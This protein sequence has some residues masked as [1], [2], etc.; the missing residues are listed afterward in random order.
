[1]TTG[2]AIFLIAAG[3]TLRYALSYRLTGIDL[4]VL[5]SIIMLAGGATLLVCLGRGLR[6]PRRRRPAAV[7]ATL[8]LPPFPPRFPSVDG[9]TERFWPQAGTER[10]G[11][12]EPTGFR[13]PAAGPPPGQHPHAGIPAMWEDLGPSGF[14]GPAGQVHNPGYPH[15]GGP[16]WW[17]AGESPPRSDVAP[18]WCGTG[19]DLAPPQ[20]G[21]PAAGTPEEPGEHARHLPPRAVWHLDDAGWP[22]ETHR[23][24]G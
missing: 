8:P 23:P 18:G 20:G 17:G 22:D 13:F 3:A 7:A 19:P 16:E 2:F 12:E 10:F 15:E 6:P 1:M 24:A 14:P 5:G 4:R 11:T 21:E 9:T